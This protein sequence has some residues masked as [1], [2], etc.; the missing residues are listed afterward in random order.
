MARDAVSSQVITNHH[1]NISSYDTFAVDWA[2]DLVKGHAT[3]YYFFRYDEDEYILI[4]SDDM[5]TEN[6]FDCSASDCT[7]LVLFREDSNII[8]HNSIGLTGTITEIGTPPKVDDVTLSGDVS[9]SVI[10]SQWKEYIVFADG[11]HVY[12]SEY[13][14]YGS[15]CE[16]MPKLVEGVSYYAFAGLA[17]AVGVIAFRLLDFIFKRV[18]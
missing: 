4:F 2:R 18:Y 6:G 15:E 12:N 11:V 16:Y 5:V 17:L 3:S 13:L 9:E 7:C 1:V 10:E 8:D 14:V